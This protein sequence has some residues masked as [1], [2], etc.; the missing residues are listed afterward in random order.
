[1]SRHCE[2]GPHGDGTHGFCGGSGGDAV[3]KY[4]MISKTGKNFNIRSI[5]NNM[6][7]KVEKTVIYKCSSFFSKMMGNIEHDLKLSHL[8]N[9]T[10]N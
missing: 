9:F 6:V 10:F 1:M 7:P 4:V 3:A 8:I 5:S 2:F